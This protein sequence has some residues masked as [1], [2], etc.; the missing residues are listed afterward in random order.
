LAYLARWC[1]IAAALLGASAVS[2]QTPGSAPETPQAEPAPAP[3]GQGTPMQ[4]PP[5]QQSPPQGPMQQGMAPPFAQG[6]GDQ[7]E[8]SAP[9]MR[10][11]QRP[12]G[13]PG[14]G[15]GGLSGGCVRD[16]RRLCSGVVP[17]GGRMIECLA[18]QRR[19]LSPSCDALLAARLAE[20]GYE[21]PGGVRPSGYG[22]PG[23]PPG[24]GAG[25]GLP[26][27]PGN[28]PPG[29]RG[30]LASCGR[31]L[32]RLCSEVPRDEVLDCLM[33]QRPELSRVCIAFLNE[34]RAPRVP[35]PSDSPAGPPSEGAPSSQSP[36]SARQNGAPP[37]GNE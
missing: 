16:I 29:R 18:S 34:T 37:P 6:T 31:E 24:H 20:R 25:P 1:V 10:S 27:S 36:P 33:S 30:L 23:G 11:S 26:P 8:H 12:F 15:F 14:P 22:P 13:M 35:A 9:P 17:G 28:G 7:S 2:A 21:P 3:P 4:R 5:M 32:R 19:A